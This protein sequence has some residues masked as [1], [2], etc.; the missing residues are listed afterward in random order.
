VHVDLYRLH[1]PSELDAL[2]LRDFA[3]PDHVWLIEWPERGAGVLPEPDVHIAL[4]VT[5]EGHLADARA[6][7]PLG[8]AWLAA[9]AAH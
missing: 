1:D 5:T 2:G 7:S 6:R 9:A 8:A 3:L 4:R